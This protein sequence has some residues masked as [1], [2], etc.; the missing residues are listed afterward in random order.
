MFQLFLSLVFFKG[1]T[2]PFES[3]LTS[4]NIKVSQKPFQHKKLLV[5]NIYS[6]FEDPLLLEQHTLST[7]CN[8]IPCKGCEHVYMTENQNV[9]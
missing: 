7:Y 2:E 4:H 8:S 6:K 1:I 5:H 3:V 9:R